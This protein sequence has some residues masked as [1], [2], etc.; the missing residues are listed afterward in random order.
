[1]DRFNED[2]FPAARPDRD[3]DPS[4]EAFRA[5]A[6]PCAIRELIFSPAPERTPAQ[7]LDALQAHDK[8]CGPCARLRAEEAATAL[9]EQWTE[10]SR[11]DPETGCTGSEMRSPLP[12]RMAMLKAAGCTREEALAYIRQVA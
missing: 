10:L 7:S 1:M 12:E 5:D 2:P 8:A 9:L 6:D 3:E 4:L 11:I